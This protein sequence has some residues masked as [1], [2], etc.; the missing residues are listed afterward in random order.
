MISIGFTGTSKG[1]TNEQMSALHGALLYAKIAYP[2]DRLWEFHFGDCVGADAEAA[3][4]AYRLGYFLV[5]HPPFDPSA[6]AFTKADRVWVPKTYLQ[7]NHDIVDAT[8]ML[9]ATPRTSKE[10]QR[11]GT[12]ATIRYA[13]KLGRGI[14]ILNP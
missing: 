7:R 1:M 10:V 4:I 12:W 5:S 13:R 9:I 6:R 14:C 3:E 11:S 8:D 2:I